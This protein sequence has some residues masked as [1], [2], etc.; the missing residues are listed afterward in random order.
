MGR[1]CCI[2]TSSP[3][4]SATP[5]DRS[6]E[7]ARLRVGTA[8]SRPET[9]PPRGG[10]SVALCGMEALALSRMDPAATVTVGDRLR[11]HPA[12]SRAGS[13]RRRGKPQP[14]FDLWGLALVLYEA[15][16]GHHPFAAADVKTVLAAATRGGVP[17]IRDYRP[18]CPAAL[19][20][21][22]RGALSPNMTQRPASA[23]AMRSQLHHV[24]AGIPEHAH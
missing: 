3:A 18:V 24:R 13:A 20:T 12:V 14:S 23:D 11:R 22:L 19:A 1:E 21:F 8:R 10:V 17:D 15:V 9:F 5:S 4:T 6:A 16:A 2:E 7:V